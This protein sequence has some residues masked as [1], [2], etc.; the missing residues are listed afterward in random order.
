MRSQQF[1]TPGSKEFRI[2]RLLNDT[3]RPRRGSGCCLLGLLLWVLVALPGSA[4]SSSNQ[5][6]DLPQARHRC[7]HS[8]GLPAHGL[9]QRESRV[10]SLHGWDALE[11]QAELQIQPASGTISGQLRLLFTTDQELD[12]LELHLEGLSWG[13]ARIGQ[14]PLAGQRLGDRLMIALGQA[15]PAPGDSAWLELDWWGVPPIQDGLGMYITTNQVYTSS[16]PWGTRHWLPCYDE[17]FDKALWSLGVRVPSGLEVLANGTLQGTTDHGDGTTT[18]QYSHAH[19]VA[20]YLLSVVAYPYAVIEGQHNG[21][22][23]TWMVYPQHT[24]EAA[25]LFARVPVMLDLYE[26]LWGDYPFESYAMGEAP[27]YGGLGGMEHQTCTTIGNQLVAAG[28]TVYETIVAHELAH[29]WW[30]DALTPVHFREAWLNEGWATYS[31]ALFVQE[32][33]GGDTAAFQDYFRTQIRDYYLSWDS[34]FDPIIDFDA[35]GFGDFFSPNQYEKAACVIHMLRHRIGEA[36]FEAGQRLWFQRHKYS[37]V[38]SEDYRAVMEE[39]GG[40]DLSHFFRQWL[41]TG[42]Y[43]SWQ[44]SAETTESAGNTRFVLGVSQSHPGMADPESRIPIRFSTG[45]AVR[46]T[47]LAVQGASALVILELPGTGGQVDFN[48]GQVALGET[49]WLPAPTQA[50]L[51]VRGW[52]L[53]DS[54][55]GNG[56]GNL[57][58]GE[59]A[60]LELTLHNTGLSLWNLEL[61]LSGLPDGLGIQGGFAVL[62][63]LAAGQDA[64]LSG[65][66]IHNTGLE[67]PAWV[68]GLLL[69][70]AEGGLACQAP[71][72]LRVGE[73]E[74]LLVD[75]SGT[76]V[77]HQ[78]WSPVLDDLDAFHDRLPVAALTLDHAERYRHLLLVSGEEGRSLEPGITEVLAA[79]GGEGRWLWISG[80]DALDHPGAGG[81]ADWL[82]V[83]VE[84]ADVPA[85]N[86]SGVPGGPLAGITALLIGSAGANNQTAPDALAFTDDIWQ[87]VMQWPAGSFSTLYAPG[88]LVMGFGAEA[89]SGMGATTARRELIDRCLGLLD[90]AWTTLDDGGTHPIPPRQTV[91]GPLTAAPNPFNPRTRLAFQLAEPGPARLV[92]HDIRGAVV[93]ELLGQD[94]DA[95]SHT[96]HF[97]GTALPSGMY[98]ARLESGGQVQVRKLLLLK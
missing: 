95:G 67:G 96:L 60:V 78:W 43:P 86:S 11:Y 56:D 76:D 92:I 81:V 20:T 27:I 79:F 80:Q 25:T 98:F 90:P 22:P 40:Q 14:T 3:V 71:L 77:A 84:T 94:L 15:A 13:N 58:L 42:G 38:D 87:P 66:V 41:H 26:R 33:G 28:G 46:D 1:S 31:E 37:V 5:T 62:P 48:R 4:A 61:Q 12:S 49:T 51:E 24:D 65:P 74:I 88:R 21:L 2:S 72:R 75:A 57:A 19:P 69:A 17:P 44:V 36:A 29:Q 85:N 30:G 89:T 39:A 53:D 52:S 82:G 83:Q 32:A 16:D 54:A 73:P 70:Q 23:L 34:A 45:Q 47:V 18:F 7:G 97:D 91:L 50:S 6:A 93:S 63:L 64:T 8:H 35:Q 68:D 10:D 55:G 59:S 9:A